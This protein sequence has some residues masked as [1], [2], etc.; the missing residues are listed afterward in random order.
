MT[1]L[2]NNNVNYTNYYNILNFLGETLQ[3]HPSI[4]SVKQGPIT[5]IDNLQFPSY[6]FGN[7][8][9]TNMYVQGTV[10]TYSVILTVG[11]KVKDI[12]TDNIVQTPQVIDFYGTDDEI[13]I[14]ANTSG[15]LN[16]II[17]YIDGGTTSFTISDRITLT[18]FSEKFRNGISGFTASFDLQT[19]NNRNKCNI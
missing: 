2:K 6:P 18:P 1:I 10:T 9:I 7:I 4:S 12:N 17:S 15:I 11:D 8:M 19:F 16:D 3:N 14:F 5:D 13:D